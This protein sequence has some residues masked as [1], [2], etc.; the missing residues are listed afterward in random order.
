MAFL[1]NLFFS[2]SIVFIWSELYHLRHKDYLYQKISQR[3]IQ[4]STLFDYIFYVSKILFIP[5]VFLG[6]FT[7]VSYPFLLIIL[8]SCVKFLIL[9]FKSQK[10]IVIYDVVSSASCILILSYTLIQHFL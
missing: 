1:T 5:W 8:I 3:N 4:N 6:L 9:T 10:A 2:L 7:T